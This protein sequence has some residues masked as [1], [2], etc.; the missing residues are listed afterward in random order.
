MNLLGIAFANPWLLSALITL[1]ILYF[2][3]RLTPPRPQK[4]L[5]APMLF[6]QQLKP[7][8][9][10]AYRSPWWLILLRLI[11]VTCLILALAAP[12]YQPSP[13]EFKGEENIL[14]IVDDRWASAPNW[15]QR[16]NNVENWLQHAQENGRG[17]ALVNTSEAGKADFS[18]QRA[19]DAL[20]TFAASQP[21][22]SDINVSG[23]VAALNEQKKTGYFEKFDTWIWFT[24][25]L[26][27]Q[28]NRELANALNDLEMENPIIYTPNDLRLVKIDGARHKQE[29]L[30]VSLSR[31]P[32]NI[33]QAGYVVA[34][35]KNNRVLAR[36]EFIF[37]AEET[38]MKIVFEQPIELRNEFYQIKLEENILGDNNNSAVKHAGGTYLLDAGNKRRKVGLASGE[39]NEDTQPLLSP[40]YFL[41]RALQPF[42]QIQEVDIGN[43]EEFDNLI[44]NGVSTLIVADIGTFSQSA[45]SKISEWVQNGGVLVRFAGPR[46]AASEQQSLIPVQLRQGSR[47]LSSTLSWS[48]PQHLAPFADKSPFAGIVVP[49]DVTV[50]KQVLA[51]PTIDL[52][53][54]IWARL[55][56]GT[57]LVTAAQRNNGWIVLFHMSAGPD[58]SSLPLSGAFVD[59]LRRIVALSY[60]NAP[61]NN[62]SQIEGDGEIDESAIVLAP[63]AILDGFGKLIPPTTQTPPLVVANTG[64][65]KPS[66]DNL[67]GFY[68]QDD[69]LLA[70]NLFHRKNEI[71]EFV[72]LDDSNLNNEWDTR[73]L[74]IE[75]PIRFKTPLLVIAF[76]TILARL[77]RRYGNGGRVDC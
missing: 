26:N 33:A 71:S 56:D 45:Q 44:D 43:D 22:P 4:Q 27:S 61:Q 7:K 52:E 34:Y 17:I 69:S 2:L 24:N 38:V 8:E 72:Q 30:E 11:L 25:G 15:E 55:Q 23:F 16:K 31:L 76:L 54:N 68:G 37:A 48:T 63:T 59:M 6:L 36:Q 10:V 53:Q 75:Q 40:V 70:L 28:G 66:L 51:E 62:T 29:N 73:N 77:Y 9:E 67:P 1:P 65:P 35:D 21:K 47:N 13:Q 32:Q 5:F 39:N 19:T 57:P 49:D 58:W 60:A 18:L 12:H 41:S 46:L 42:A 64:S 3:L 20:N 74:E 14:M 50:T